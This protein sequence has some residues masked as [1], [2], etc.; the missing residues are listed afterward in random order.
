[1]GRKEREGVIPPAAVPF[2]A[3]A[4]VGR[5]AT[6]GEDGLPY[7]V[8][9][10]YVLWQGDLWSPLDTKPKRVPVERLRRVQ[11]IVARPG[12]GV[13]IDR[14]SED[15][16]ELAYV[17]IRGHARLVTSAEARAAVVPLLR[18]KYPQY[19]SMPALDENPLLQITPLAV[20]VW[21]H[22]G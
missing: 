6:I 17:Q 9:F 10:C 14:W 22:L 1:M 7:L 21:G 5:L 18:E 2:V 19:R 11:N 13:V 8:P 16:S 20:V 15:W 3:Q 4:R 12:V